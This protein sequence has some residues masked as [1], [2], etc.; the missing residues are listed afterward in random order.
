[1]G[2]EENKQIDPLKSGV[3][4]LVDPAIDAVIYVTSAEGSMYKAFQ[5]YKGDLF[6]QV[7]PVDLYRYLSVM[8]FCHGTYVTLKCLEECSTREELKHAKKKWITKLQAKGEA[9]LNK[10][11]G[12]N[13]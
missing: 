5:K 3:F 6:R 1:M 7:G 4:G 10:Q 8:K 9:F 2:V 12:R 13:K 11:E